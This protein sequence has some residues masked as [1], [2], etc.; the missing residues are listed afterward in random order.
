[1]RNFLAEQAQRLAKLSSLLRR[2]A[3]SCS[4]SAC[5][6]AVRDLHAAVLGQH[7]PQ[8]RPDLCI[9]PRDALADIFY[10]GPRGRDLIVFFHKAGSASRP[11]LITAL[12]TCGTLGGLERA[13]VAGLGVCRCR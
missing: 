6:T 8:H 9:H 4:S 12:L 13:R 10:A 1:M 11:P 3:V 5:T 2:P 7:P